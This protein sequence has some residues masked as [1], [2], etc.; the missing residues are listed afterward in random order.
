VKSLVIGHWLS[1][2][3]ERDSLSQR[4]LALLIGYTQRPDWQHERKFDGYRAL[5]V[6]APWADTTFLG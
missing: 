3:A 4:N 6:R 1:A 2:K 5:P